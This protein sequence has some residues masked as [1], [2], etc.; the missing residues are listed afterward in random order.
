MSF[1]TRRKLMSVLSYLGDKKVLMH[2]TLSRALSGL[3]W[4]I[5]VSSVG[6]MELAGRPLSIGEVLSG[7][8]LG[9]GE[10]HGGN[11]GRRELD[12]INLALVRALKGATD[13]NKLEVG[14]VGD[15]HELHVTR[16]PQDGVVSS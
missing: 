12:A 6:S 15:G 13:G 4:T 7:I 11:G 16:A 3:I 5:L 2:T 9:I 10:L 1:F 14:V 8:F